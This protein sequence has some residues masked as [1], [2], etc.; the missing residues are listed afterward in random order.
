M[1]SL[2]VEKSSLLEQL[3]GKRRPSKSKAAELLGLTETKIM[4]EMQRVCILPLL[5][6][7]YYGL[8]A[9]LIF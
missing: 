3:D 6:T 5:A 4:V 7:L 9:N 1:A 8:N 2:E